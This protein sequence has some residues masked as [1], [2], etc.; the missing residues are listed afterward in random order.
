MSD[1]R[2][3]LRS[4]T[5][6]SRHAIG[7]LSLLSGHLPAQESL[8][9]APAAAVPPAGAMPPSPASSRP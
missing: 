3:T 9:A 6:T 8:P 1:L 4:F 2:F 7:L 5:K